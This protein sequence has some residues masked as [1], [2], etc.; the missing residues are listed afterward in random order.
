MKPFLAG[1]L[2][3][4]GSVAIL[5]QDALTT[6]SIHYKVVADAAPARVL[7]ATYAA[8]EKSEMHRHPDGFTIALR[9]TKVRFNLPDGKTE[10]LQMTA[11]TARYTAATTHNPLNIGP[12]PI[13]ALIVELKAAKPGTAKLPASRPGLTLTQLAT[14]ARGTAYRATAASTF[15]EPAGTKHDYDQVVIALGTAAMSLKLEGEPAKTSWSRGDVVI[16]PRGVA[17]ESKNTGGRTVEFI[18][19]AIK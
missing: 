17:H 19:V 18:I 5:A 4:A 15:A 12:G 8:G 14:G 3:L 11:N 13:E 2:V 1:A 10:D 16:I 9:S 6:D 7:K